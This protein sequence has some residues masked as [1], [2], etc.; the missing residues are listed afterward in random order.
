MRRFLTVFR[1]EM[2]VVWTRE[3]ATEEVRCQCIETGLC[4]EPRF[5]VSSP[6]AA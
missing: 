2:M 6:L 5:R 1:R 4:V 3:V